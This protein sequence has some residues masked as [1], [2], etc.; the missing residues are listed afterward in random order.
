MSTKKINPRE[1]VT[2]YYVLSAASDSELSRALAVFAKY[3]N[4][5]IVTMGFN[6]LSWHTVISIRQTWLNHQVLDRQLITKGV[7]YT[8]N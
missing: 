1:S 2:V 8:A 7:A 4:H 5:K 3:S 6:N